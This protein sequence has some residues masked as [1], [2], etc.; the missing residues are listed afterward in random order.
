MPKKLPRHV[1]K[2]RSKGHTYLSF[3]RGKGPRI[4]LPNDPDSHEF[5][6]AYAAALSGE[7]VPTGPTLRRDA[8]GTI[9]ALIVDYKKNGTFTALRDPS[10]KGY[11]TRLETIRLSMVTVPS[12][13]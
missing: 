13:D 1:E 4:R 8:P 9:G 5:R 6:V 12:R 3:R 11:T 2:N 7:S 10:K